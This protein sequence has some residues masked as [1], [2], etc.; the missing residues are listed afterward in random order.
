MSQY[1][2]GFT[3][4]KSTES[5]A[6]LPSV[7]ADAQRS[8]RRELSSLLRLSPLDD[9]LQEAARGLPVQGLSA[10]ALSNAYRRRVASLLATR[11]GLLLR[12]LSEDTQA[13]A[14]TLPFAASAPARAA[15]PTEEEIPVH[16]AATELPGHDTTIAEPRGST[17]ELLGPSH[18]GPSFASRTTPALA[19]PDA[20]AGDTAAHALY[21]VID[22][23]PTWT[24]EEP[25]HRH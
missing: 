3:R 8:L 17:Q 9:V 1:A 14:M 10:V 21:D 7:V 13:V 6:A 11:F 18:E 22:N 15:L 4:K 25:T 24:G 5:E 23:E 19:L 16:S 2:P 12:E 20:L